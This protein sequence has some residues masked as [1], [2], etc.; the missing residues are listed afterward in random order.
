M[1]F[2]IGTT[3]ALLFLDGWLRVAV[4]AGVVAIEIFEIFVWLR[5]RKVRA[6]TGAEGMLG[7]TGVALSDLQPD[8]QVKVR[9]R[10]W[11]ATA[12]EGLAAGDEVVVRAVSGLELTVSRL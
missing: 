3:L 4:I 1:A 5:W 8:G 10:I 11:K 7:A 6:T 9:G 12:T 2:I